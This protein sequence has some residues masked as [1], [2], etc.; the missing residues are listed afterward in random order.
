ML[1]KTVVFLLCC[2]LVSFAGPVKVKTASELIEWFNT[3][4]GDTSKVIIEL[5]ADLDFTN[6]GL[7]YPLGFSQGSCT[8]FS[9]S[10]KGREHRI[11]GLVMDNKNDNTYSS[12]GLFCAL[13]QANIDDLI[14]DESC[15][16]TGVSAGALSVMVTNGG[17]ENLINV[18]NKAQVNGDHGVGG[19]FGF[20]NRTLGALIF[21]RCKN[22]GSVTATENTAGGFIGYVENSTGTVYFFRNTTNSGVI[23]GAQIAGGFVGFLKNNQHISVI[24]NKSINENTIE[25]KNYASGFLGYVEMA[26]FKEDFM[27]FMN[28]S[29]NKGAVK[30]RGMACGFFCSVDSESDAP[31]AT[32]NNN[33]N[34]GG[35]SGYD[36]FGFAPSVTEGYNDVSI[37]TVTGTHFSASFWRTAQE[38]DTMITTESVCKNCA[39]AIWAVKNAD[40]TYD[41]AGTKMHVHDMLNWNVAL[42]RRWKQWLFWNS[43]LE[44]QETT[45]NLNDGHSLAVS[46]TALS[47]VFLMMIQGVFSQ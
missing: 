34:S 24:V 19:F 29:I 23:N 42:V 36:A 28:N 46:F 7:K 5:T 3:H 15:K 4:S 10:L 32:I 40:G 27:V 2:C 18:E 20:V 21:E 17:N 26:T 35:I 41:V 47:L 6:A 30:G 1:T 37:G 39:G 12:A 43:Q 44:F 16:F 8:P 31:N 14:I 13:E 45:G 38:F 25:G 9:G 11:K 33:V 22:T